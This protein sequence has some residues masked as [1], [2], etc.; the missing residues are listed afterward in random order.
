MITDTSDE[1]FYFRH[2]ISHCRSKNHNRHAA[3][4]HKD[5]SDQRGELTAEGKTDPDNVIQKRND[6]RCQYNTMGNAGKIEEIREQLNG[7]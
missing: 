6:K 4:G 7:L 1:V 3:Q 2:K 5:R